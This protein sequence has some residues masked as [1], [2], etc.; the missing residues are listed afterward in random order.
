MWPQWLARAALEDTLQRHARTEGGDA[1]DKVDMTTVVNALKIKGLASGS[2]KT[3][4]DAMPKIRNYAMHA[5]WGKIKLEDVRS[6]A[7][8]VEEFRLARALHGRISS[9][10]YPEGGFFDGFKQL[11]RP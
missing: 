11:I 9:T 4:L 6:V 5:D 1:D 2:Q 8:F 7:G 3:L 10:A